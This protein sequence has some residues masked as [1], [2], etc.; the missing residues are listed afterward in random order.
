MHSP[1]NTLRLPI[2][3]DACEYARRLLAGKT[4]DVV[5]VDLETVLEFM[6]GDVVCL[7][8]TVRA[9]AYRRLTTSNRGTP[10]HVYLTDT[11]CIAAGLPVRK[12]TKPLVG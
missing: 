7:R 4:W 6:R 2:P 11:E 3:D 5:P 12:N 9:F 1:P 8:G 10:L